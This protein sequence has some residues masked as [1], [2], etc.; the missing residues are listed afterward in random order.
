MTMQLDHKPNPQ[1]QVAL[2]IIP[3]IIFTTYYMYLQKALDSSIQVVRNHKKLSQDCCKIM[4]QHLWKILG[5][6]REKFQKN[7]VNLGLKKEL[8]PQNLACYRL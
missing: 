7:I 1:A 3:E 5:T 8:K 6:N 4:S 2:C